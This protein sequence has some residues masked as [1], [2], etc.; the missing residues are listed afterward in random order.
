M[1]ILSD[2]DFFSNAKEMHV[3]RT[4][5]FIKTLA[6]LELGE[7]LKASLNVALGP[8]SLPTVGYNTPNPS[9]HP[10]PNLKQLL[11]QVLKSG[12]QQR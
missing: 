11:N 1:N 2:D 10:C 4:L 3:G 12:L 7:Y 6:K 5:I 9:V 8:N